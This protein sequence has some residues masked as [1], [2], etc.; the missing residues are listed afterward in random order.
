MYFFFFNPEKF[1]A[2]P[3]IYHL[4]NNHLKHIELCQYFSELFCLDIKRHIYMISTINSSGL[5]KMTLK[6][7]LKD[8]KKASLSLNYFKTTLKKLERNKIIN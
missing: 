1:N 5:F 7:C 3:D 8:S 2:C 4:N 6:S